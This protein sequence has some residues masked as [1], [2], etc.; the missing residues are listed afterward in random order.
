VSHSYRLKI[1]RP[2]LKLKVATRIPAQL[3]GGTGIEITKASGVYT[4]DLNYNEIGTTTAYNDAL[5]A[6]TYIVSW[7]SVGDDFS[8]INITDLK[9]DLA[10]TFGGIYQP[11]DA[12]LTALAGLNSTAGLL[13]QT[14][15]DTF[16]KRTLTAGA[17]VGV[18]NGDGV[19]GNP[20][21]AVTDA[22][23]VA[24]GGLTSAADKLP[25]FTGSGTAALADFSAFARTLVDDAD[26]AAMRVTLGLT[27]GTDVQ[28]FDADLA[29]LAAN[30]TDGLWAHTGAG[31]GAARTLTAPAAGI[32]V[33]NPAGVAGNPT[34]VLAND[35]AALEGLASTGIARRTG[36]DAWSV[37]TAVS[38]AELA[39][40]AAYT[41]KGNNTSGAATPTD[42]DIAA[43][44]TKASPAA[45][46]WVI[47]SDQAASGAWKKADVSVLAAAGSVSSVNGQTGAVVSY[48]PPQ[49]RLTL[50]TA[51][52]VMTT[53]AAAQSTVYYTPACGDLVPIYDG[54]NMVPT[55]FAELS[56]AVSDTTKSPAAVAADSVYDIFVWNDGGTIRATRGPAWT[57]ITTRSAGT[58]LT[59]VKGIMLN[60][61]SITNGPA[62]SRGTWVGTIAS[63]AAGSIDW[64]YAAVSA[65]GTAGK[66]GVWN[67]YNQISF[68]SMVGES[69][70]SWTYATAAWRQANAQANMKISFVRGINEVTVKATYNSLGQ[71]SASGGAAVGIG[72]DSTTAFVGSPA[73]SA[74]SQFGALASHYS[75]LPGIGLRTLYPIEYSRGAG[76]VTLY[77]DIGDATTYQSGMIV[78]FDA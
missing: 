9:T 19:S 24:I 31:T 71:G 28:A 53:T 18:T 61:A 11:M 26:Q 3:V 50:V 48:F 20:T 63:N 55:V 2:S 72:L 74:A 23:L 60:N 43:L 44:T 41:F 6:T 34:L 49:G 16:T 75:G 69:A 70:D 47:I 30:S 8:K 68:A 46:D 73:I 7:E 38:N 77:G 4:F 37:G 5:E 76:T 58:A 59:R 27:P 13:V 56:Q 32:T 10:T 64:I 65:G 51:T 57:N 36:S 25:Y 42:V 54:T 67:T 39:T 17:L 40:M 12:T 78:E 45:G 35:L 22:E 14:A 52:P 29:A 33:T 15:A 1:S 66:F 21:V 62:A